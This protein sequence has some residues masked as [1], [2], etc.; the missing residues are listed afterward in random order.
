MTIVDHLDEA[1]SPLRCNDAVGVEVWSPT[2]VSG[3]DWNQVNISSIPYSAPLMWGLPADGSIPL[4]P[5][6]HVVDG[7][8]QDGLFVGSHGV[9]TWGIKRA[10]GRYPYWFF[11]LLGPGS[12]DPVT[13]ERLGEDEHETFIKVLAV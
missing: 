10:E 2:G 12:E 5:Y 4:E 8:T 6:H 7:E 13:G 9:T 1:K 11:R 3:Y